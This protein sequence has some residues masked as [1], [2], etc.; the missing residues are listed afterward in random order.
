MRNCWG[1]GKPFEGEGAVYRCPACQEKFEKETDDFNKKVDAGKIK[2]YKYLM[3]G[4]VDAAYKPYLTVILLFINTLVIVLM[5]VNGYTHSPIEVAM[6]F[7]AQHTETVWGGEWWRLAASWFV[8]FGLQHFAMNMISLWILGSKIEGSFGTILFALVYI[9]SGLG[10][11]VA[12][13]IF[14]SPLAISAGASGA[15]NGLLGFAYVYA[16][17]RR[18]YIGTLDSRSLMMWIVVIQIFGVIM[19]NVGWIA[20]LGGLVT[21]A[22]LGLLVAKLKK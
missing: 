1:C 20:H 4:G 11:S 9:V 18:V 13:L 19:P 15:I 17:I 16:R 3:I 10:S 5:H 21:G 22:F 7:G 6:R 12:T 8:H 2:R 14:A